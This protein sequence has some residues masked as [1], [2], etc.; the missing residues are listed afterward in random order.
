MLS[1]GRQYSMT[2]WALLDADLLG[3]D[4]YGGVG[5]L[6]SYIPNARSDNT[7]AYKG[8][9]NGITAGV[10][11]SFGRDATGTGN[12][13]GQGTCAGTDS[14]N[15]AA[16]RQWSAM[17]RYDGTRFGVAAAYD[18]QRGG[19]SAA[20]SFF[21]GAPPLALTNPGDKDVR[22]QL[23]GYVLAGSLKIGGGWLGR[24][25]DTVDASVP[26]VRSNLFYVTAAYPISAA[27][28]VDGGIYRIINHVQ[29]ARGTIIALRTTYLLSKRTA[30][31]LQGGY[32]FNSA[33]ASYTLS[34]GGPG[35][36]PGAGMNQLGFMVGLRHSF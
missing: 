31:Y 13:P 18:E 32:L 3:P 33:H 20:A 9:W 19:P 22:M 26:D 24:Q 15:Y 12:S 8:T 17:L 1:F 29:N 2:F 4:I 30:V 23:N 21:D 35:A 27:L 11:Y 25:V 7:L 36:T 16:C 14:G 28:I 6:D 34:Q 5:S 10:T